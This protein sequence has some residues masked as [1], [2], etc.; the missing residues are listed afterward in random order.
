MH[1]IR[2]QDY[3]IGAGSFERARS[4]GEQGSRRLPA[5]RMLQPLDFVEIEAVEDDPC[6]ME[7]AEVLLTVSLI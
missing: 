7:P 1:C 2:A 6:R 3:E 5:A 4:V